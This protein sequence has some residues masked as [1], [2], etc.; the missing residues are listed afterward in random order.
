MTDNCD[1]TAAARPTGS[2]F[3]TPPNPTAGWADIQR[4]GDDGWLQQ[5]VEDSVIDA[6]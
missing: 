4:V 5:P 2:A 3:L 1:L 6:N